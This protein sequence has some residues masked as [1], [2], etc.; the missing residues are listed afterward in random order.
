MLDIRFGEKGPRMVS[1]TTKDDSRATKRRGRGLPFKAI[2]LVA[3]LGVSAGAAEG[4]L[5]LLGF[6]PGDPRY[7][8]EH[9]SIRVEPGGKLCR[10]DPLLGYVALPGRFEITIR[11]LHYC[12][13]HGADT[14]RVMP[15]SPTN[16]K[17]DI[18]CFG[19][20]FT[21]GFAVNDPDPYPVVLQQFLPERRIINFGCDG[22]GTLQCLLALEAELARRPMPSL[23]ILGHLG[24]HDERDVLARRRIKE[25]LAFNNLVDGELPF[26]RCG[27]GGELRIERAPIRYRG[28][29]LYRQSA[30]VNL[31]DDLVNQW[32]YEYQRRQGVTEKLLMEMNRRCQDRKIPFI[33]AAVYYDTQATADFCRRQNIPL[34]DAQCNLS[35]PENMVAPWDDHPSRRGHRVIGLRLLDGLR[36]LGFDLG[37]MEPAPWRLSGL[38]DTR[39]RLDEQD[40]LVRAMPNMANEKEPWSI[41]A[42]RSWLRLEQG[43]K[44]RLQLELR[45]ESRR[46]VNVQVSQAHEPWTILG[47]QQEVD[48]GPAWKKVER[49]FTAIQ[50]DPNAMISIWLA[51][52]DVPVEIRGGTL[53]AVP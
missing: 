22:Y 9:Y 39:A 5:R 44:Y 53:T 4:T 25:L 47:L 30:L 28:L 33:V 17:G 13:T 31:L 20:S 35:Q 14:L 11:D 16:P 6:Y 7:R 19:C 50:T 8:R 40:D 24:T 23:V 1:D 12:Q 36:T 51:A 49:E 29:P 43:K 34:V 32:E 26:A 18:W 42:Y 41:F 38:G 52:S 37:R 45:A 48:I 3:A 27:P 15:V 10:P 2:V 46:A 21:H